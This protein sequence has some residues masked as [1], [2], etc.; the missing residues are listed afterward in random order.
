MLNLSLVTT[1]KDQDLCAQE[2]SAG[3][4]LHGTAVLR[5]LVEPWA[6]SGRI[7]CADSY[8]ASVEAAELLQGLGLRFIGVVKTATCLLPMAKLS[9]EELATRGDRRSMVAK[10]CDGNI[11]MM[12]MVWM[13]RERRYF[14]A[15]ASSTLEGNSYTRARRRQFEDGP[16]RIALDV[17]QPDIIP[18]SGRDAYLTPTKMRRRNCIGE[19]QTSRA[20]GDYPCLLA[21][22]RCHRREGVSLA[23]PLKRRPELLYHM[24]ELHEYLKA[25]N[26]HG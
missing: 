11:R 2:T 14:I 21:M 16:A 24:Q 4:K 13:D 3:E 5:R 12:A 10:Y 20:Q 6:G 7:V 25:F 26:R 1:A 23:L 18:R 19:L 9:E 17:L 22:C 15:T 8:F